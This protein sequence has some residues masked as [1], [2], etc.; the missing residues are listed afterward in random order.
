MDLA[1][2][3][4]SILGVFRHENELRN[5]DTLVGSAAALWRCLAG[6]AVLQGPTLTKE[7]WNG[8]D[9]KSGVP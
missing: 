5:E 9:G 6:N 4:N 2:F 7:G 1:C 8:V 3:S